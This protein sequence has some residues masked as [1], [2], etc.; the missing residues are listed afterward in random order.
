MTAPLDIALA[1]A[2]DGLP[3]FPCDAHKRPCVPK[4][5]GGHGF[6]DATTD[7]TEL[8]RL[9]SF[10]GAALVG[11][12]T[13]RASGFDAL[14]FDYRHGAAAW[15]AEHAD[16][17]PATRARYEPAAAASICSLS[18]RMVSAR[19]LAASPKAWMCAAPAVM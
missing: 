10:P 19:P 16:A 8:H 12:P 2:A 15:Q 18:L 1:L 14:D 6:H 5:A 9:F 3:C 11:I 13:G 4:A 7:P 17:L